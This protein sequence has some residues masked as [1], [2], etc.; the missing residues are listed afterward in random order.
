MRVL[1]TFTCLLLLLSISCEEEEKKGFCV[2][3]CDSNGKTTTCYADFTKKKCADYNKNHVDGY[4]WE[5][6]DGDICPP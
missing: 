5:F 3:C 2:A 1:V 6:Y 4:D